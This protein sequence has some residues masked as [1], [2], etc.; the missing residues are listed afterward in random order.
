MPFFHDMFKA[1]YTSLQ[2]LNLDWLLTKVKN[3]LRFVPDDGYVGQILRRTS[4]GAEWSDEQGA[5]GSVTSVNGMQGDV[6]LDAS[7]V[8]A[9]PDTYTSV[10]DLKVDRYGGGTDTLTGSVSIIGTGCQVLSTGANRVEVLVTIPVRS[11]NSMTGN[12]VIGKSDVGLGNVDNVQQYSATNPPPYPVTS[13]NGQTGAVTIST[14]SPIDAYPVGS[15]YMS[16]NSTDPGSLFGG[17]WVRLKDKFLLAAGDVYNAGDTGG[18][19]T[20]TLTVDEIPSHHHGL[21]RVTSAVSSGSNF[22][23]IASTGTA[24]DN[25][26]T[27][28]GGGQ[29]HNNMPPYIVVYMWQR[30][31]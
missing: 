25:I 31:A 19:A 30:T 16:V 5:G 9:L 15:I 12:V 4:S 26:I 28:T 18:E 23:R 27:D 1:P 17:T 8:G 7:D 2:E 20:H 24:D 21:K 6:V 3:I 14:G 10:T 22:A 13:V 11:V 29:A